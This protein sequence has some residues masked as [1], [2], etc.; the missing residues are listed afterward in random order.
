MRGQSPNQNQGNLFFTPLK[1]LLNPA[2]RLYQLSTEIDW[3]AFESEFGKDYSHTGR[4]SHPVRLMVGLLI[5]KQLDNL[6]DETVVE[7]WIENPYYQYF[8]GMDVFQWNFPIDPS[9]LVYFRNRIGRAGAELILQSSVQIHG[10]EAEESEISVDTTVQ[11]KAITF[12]TDAKLH[13]RIMEYCWAIADQE[14][15]K[16]RQSYKRKIKN[17]LRS[18]YNSQH[19]KRRKAASKGLRKIRTITGRLVRDVVRKLPED[20]LA[21]Y[22]QLLAIFHK[23]MTQ[24]RGDSDKVYAIHAPE[25][26]CIAKGKAYPKYEFGAKAAIAQTKKGGIIVAAESF[27]GNPHDS[28]TL[29]P[30]LLQYHRIL[31]TLPEAAIL[32]RGF[33]GVKTI[34]GVKMIRPDKPKNNNTP[35]QKR[36]ARKRFRRRAAIEPTIGHLK[37]RF[38]LDRNWLKGSKGDQFNLLMAAA[39]FNFKKWMNRMPDKSIFL[40]FESS[41]TLYYN[42]LQKISLTQSHSG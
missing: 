20:R 35:Y 7:K 18:Q 12:P 33:R 24:K 37:H 26:S 11:S 34:F 19:P 16:L 6:G 23:V 21:K 13:K 36:K 25:V 38:R 40:F 27:Q 32:D 31:D 28:Y 9:D 30:I 10:E 29:L 1:A 14:G 17:Y 15:I 8:C 39:A 2:H 4:P 42:Q 22:G 41:R 5:L 3:S